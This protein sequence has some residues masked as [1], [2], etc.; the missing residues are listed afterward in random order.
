MKKIIARALMVIATKKKYISL[1]MSA[2]LLLS[3]LPV[4]ETAFAA[5][6]PGELYVSGQMTM[7]TGTVN[8]TEEGSLDW[9]QFNSGS[10]SSYARKNIS[11][12]VIQDIKANKTTSGPVTDCPFL[13]SFSDAAPGSNPTSRTGVEIRGLDSEYSFTIPYLSNKPQ[14]LKVYSSVWAGDITLE[15]IVNGTVMYTGTYGKDTSSGQTGQCFDI[16]FQLSGPS[17]EVSVRIYCSLN[18][19]TQWGGASHCLQAIT[20]S[21]EITESPT[22]MDYPFFLTAASACTEE[23]VNESAPASN[24]VDGETNTFWHTSWRTGA[25]D[26]TLHA[27]GTGT[28]HGKENVENGHWLQIDLGA[29]TK[30]AGLRYLPR[31]NGA[32]GRVTTARVYVS[33]DGS[34]FTQTAGPLTWTTTT[35]EK[36]VIF[37]STVDARYVLLLS[38]APAAYCTAALIHIEVP[39]DEASSLKWDYAKAALDKLNTVLIGDAPNQYPQSTWDAAEIAIKSAVN[40]ESFESAKLDIDN[41]MEVFLNSYIRHSK[42][43]LESL[44]ATA[45]GLLESADGNENVSQG[46]IDT[47]SAEIDSAEST[48]GGSADEIHAAYKTLNAAVIQFRGILNGPPTKRVTPLMGWASWNLYRAKINEAELIKQ[49]NALVSTGLADAGYTFF[50]I[51]DGFFGGRGP[52]GMVRTHPTKFPN[53][54]RIFADMAH[55][56]GLSAG[57]YTDAGVVTCA[58]IWDRGDVGTYGD[59]VGLYGYEEQDLRMYLIDWGYDFIKVDWCGGQRMGLSE[60]MQYTKIGNI[61]E[62]IRNETG[63]YK[64]YNVCRWQFPG[65]WVVDIADSWRVGSDLSASFSSVM[66]QV[67]QVTNLAKYHGPGHVNDLDMMQVGNGMTYEEDKAHFTMWCMMSTP[68][69]LGNDLTKISQ[70]TLDIVTNRELIAL[71][72]DPACLQAT[73]VKTTGN[74]QIWVKDLGYAGSLT[75]AVTLL[76]R[77]TSPLDITVNFDEIGF[78][79]DVT[80][81]DLWAHQDL[82]VGMSYTV[83]VPAHGVVVLKVSDANVVD[84]NVITSFTLDGV[85][86]KIDSR[87]GTISVTL[88]SGTDVTSLAPVVGY[89]GESIDPPSGA[90]RDFTDPVDY[91]VAAADGSTRTYTVT[92]TVRR[93]LAKVSGKMT[94]T[95]GSVNLTEE[96]SVDWA[97]FNSN[98]ISNYARKDILAPIIQN[99]QAVGA[100]SGPITDAPFSFAYSDAAPGSVPRNRYGIQVRG[101]GTGYTFTLPYRSCKPHNLKVYSSVW[102]GDVT[103]EFLVNGIVMYTGTYGKDISGGQRGQCF[104]IDYQIFDPDDQVSVRLYCSTNLDTQW[105]G[106]S[107]LLQAITLS[108]DEAANNTVLPPKAAI[109]DG[110]ITVTT[111]MTRCDADGFDKAAVIAALYD[112]DG[113]LKG[114]DRKEA[115]ISRTGDFV[116]VNN[117]IAK[118]ADV[119]D[120]KL[121]VFIW[122]IESNVPLLESLDLEEPTVIESAGYINPATAKDK[123]LNGAVLIDVRSKEEYDE[124]HI[125]GA[126]N[127]EYTDI[128]TKAEEIVTDKNAE[129][130]VYCSA[131]KRSAQALQTLNYLAYVNV[132]NLGSMSNW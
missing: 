115:N 55:E 104:D 113:V 22:F 98:S 10:V 125:D 7:K 27:N 106:A 92:V 65:E 111:Q 96:G 120:F 37:D 15:F 49:M 126:I 103:L 132:Y 78:P 50:N 87:A 110:V 99:I 34:S 24:V 72:Q 8:L 9:V 38:Q 124:R 88:P 66:Y 79:G 52:D 62:D 13:F 35:D 28:S 76:N 74:A 128:F 73:L 94:V 53:G 67:D 130:I 97:Q 91:K 95:S 29:V 39:F 32:N 86:G 122:D 47:F 42:S 30:V 77:G 68:L 40:A 1:C 61:I 100:T 57:I 64:V 33:T 20:L 118:P 129:I 114:L 3:C 69:M 46:D 60:Q 16:D 18:R 11:K 85:A 48:L 107:H 101:L 56:K 117:I 121:K 70:Q 102:G 127:I 54:M 93:G 4:W 119:Q 83:N 19:D 75:K 5:P 109:A 58:S 6:E 23:T 31:Q 84:G 63:K 26:N 36:R 51:D 89:T 81:R 43:Q 105:G 12:R 59:D 17:D 44:I 21:G 2:V 25:N 41:A 82:D 131:G 112:G 71:N 116:T 45:H 108:C 14:N 80:A 123:V 90:A